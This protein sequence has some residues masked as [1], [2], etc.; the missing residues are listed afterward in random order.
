MK[1]DW[2]INHKT[3]VSGSCGCVVLFLGGKLVVFIVN[4]W[5]Y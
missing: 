2:K 4:S 3:V 1:G 5:M